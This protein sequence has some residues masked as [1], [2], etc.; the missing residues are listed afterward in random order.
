MA[1]EETDIRQ[2]TGM[3][4]NI[5][6]IWAEPAGDA[7]RRR[8]SRN[9]VIWLS[10]FSMKK[11]DVTDGLADLARCGYTAVSFDLCEHGE[12]TIGSET[13]QAMRERVGSNRR[14]YFWPIIARTAEDFPRVI[15]WA[16][17][18]FGIE[19]RVM[20]GGISMGGDISLV[21]AGIDT[22]IEAVC[23]AIA[24]PD[25]LRPGS[26]DPQGTGDAYSRMFYDRYNPITNLERYRHKPLIQFI[27]AGADRFVPPEAAHRFRDA[28]RQHIYEAC[29][30][31]IGIEE[32]AGM[33]HGFPAEM[34]N[35]C[36]QWLRAQR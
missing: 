21:A 9:L 16:V 1:K 4:G 5:P 28:L 26:V 18:R 22:R 17:T 29:P 24:T 14:L 32:L 10:G 30:E 34:W 35:R 2:G 23:A 13:H 7:E 8:S 3:A 12:R 20:A 33:D 6:V 36:L 27:N 19:E 11:E 25:W 15:D 31:R